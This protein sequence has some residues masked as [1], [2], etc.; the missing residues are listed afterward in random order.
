MGAQ[1]G[2]DFPRS[3]EQLLGHGVTLLS[4]RPDLSS[5]LH[6][7]TLFLPFFPHPI[8]PQLL[9]TCQGSSPRQ[10]PSATPS[11]ISALRPLLMSWRTHLERSEAISEERSGGRTRLGWRQQGSWGG[12]ILGPSLSSVPSARP[13]PVQGS[14][15]LAVVPG[16]G[17]VEQRVQRKQQQ[18]SEKG[19][20]RPSRPSSLC[21]APPTQA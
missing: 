10:V 18:L 12:G 8:S 9:H 19:L 2:Y 1:R 5:P 15:L 3:P 4:L 14:G 17:Q 13:E 7:L 20:A 11:P 21:T 16:K 6:P